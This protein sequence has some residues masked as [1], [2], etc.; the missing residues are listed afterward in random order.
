MIDCRRSPVSDERPLDPTL[1][2]PYALTHTLT[3]DSIR[4]HPPRR[5]KDKM[6]I[7]L[8]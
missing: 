5:A 1:A 6:R 4:L 8:H 3:H 2:S 7:K